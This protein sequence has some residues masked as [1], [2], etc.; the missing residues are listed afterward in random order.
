[1]CPLGSV[2]HGN[3]RGR[4]ES[5]FQHPQIPFSKLKFAGEGL[6]FVNIP[7]CVPSPWPHLFP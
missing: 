6:K 5:D 4:E 7:G 3:P 1:M 2:L